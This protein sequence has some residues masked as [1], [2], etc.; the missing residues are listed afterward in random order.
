MRD[1]ARLGYAQ[2]RAQARFGARPTD[3]FWRELEAGRALPHLVEIVRAS[4]LATAVESLPAGVDPHALEA[5]LRRRWVSVVEETAS[6]YPARVRPSFEWLGWLPWLASLTWLAQGMPSVAWMAQDARI[7]ELAGT[8]PI[9]RASRLLDGPLAPFRP[10]FE[11]DPQSSVAR[12][13]HAHWKRSWPALGT[14]SRPGLDR[15]DAALSRITPGEDA[16][17]RP[18]FDALTDAVETVATRLFRRHAGTPV[19]GLAL[20]VLLRL[21]HMRLRAALATARLFGEARAA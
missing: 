21:D 17:P 5:Q 2:A 9:E 19:A 10:A 15:L 14:D 8:E 20:L 16:D 11:A 13:W 3:S 4:P 1:T 6:W 18:G 7:A 12:A